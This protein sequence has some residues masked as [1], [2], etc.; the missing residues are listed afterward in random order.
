MNKHTAIW[1]R[2]CY[3]PGS[4]IL[5]P[6]QKR[7][8]VQSDRDSFNS[9]QAAFY[10]ACLRTGK[11][12]GGCGCRCE[13]VRG[14]RGLGARGCR[15]WKGRP[16]GCGRWGGCHAWGIGYRRCVGWGLRA[17]QGKENLAKILVIWRSIKNFRPVCSIRTRIKCG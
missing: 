6:G 5:L 8:Q 17:G 7:C 4:I 10:L 13:S 14:R 9:R 15:C 2:T 3:R 12:L 11:F 1:K 16:G